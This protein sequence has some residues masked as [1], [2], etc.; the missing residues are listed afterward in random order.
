MGR[1]ETDRGELAAARRMAGAPEPAQDL[2]PFG[3]ICSDLML[4]AG[5]GIVSPQVRVKTERA[6]RT[7]AQEAYARG[8][9]DSLTPAAVAGW[10]EGLAGL[11]RARRL[12][13]RDV[14][15]LQALER[16]VELLRRPA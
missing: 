12:G 1:S 13:S 11:L 5:A 9:A 8:A 7:L 16:A 3:S 6:V 4:V 14:A 15:D 2:R 10:L